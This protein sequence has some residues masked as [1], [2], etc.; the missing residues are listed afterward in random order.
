MY[1][2][3]ESQRIAQR[4]VQLK[5]STKEKFTSSRSAKADYTIMTT[6]LATLS[7]MQPINLM[8]QLLL[9]RL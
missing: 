3:T 6:R 8:I 1:L 4:D 2:D 7:L 9:I 5:C